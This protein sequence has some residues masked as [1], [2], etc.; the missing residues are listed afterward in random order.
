VGSTGVVAFAVAD[1]FVGFLFAC[2]LFGT[3]T[4]LY[5]PPVMTLLTNAFPSE[6]GR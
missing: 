2:F 3:G 1:G 4:G 6:G 5:I